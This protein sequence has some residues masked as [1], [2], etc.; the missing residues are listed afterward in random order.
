[1]AEK[2]DWIFRLH[3]EGTQEDADALLDQLLEQFPAEGAVTVL[4]FHA[5]ELEEGAGD[6]QDQES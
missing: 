1:M 3:F 6:G 2:Q 4:G 5:Q